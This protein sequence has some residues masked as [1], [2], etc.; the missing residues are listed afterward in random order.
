MAIDWDAID[1]EINQAAGE[2]DAQLES[3]ISSLTRMKDNE[4]NE[5]FPEKADKEKLIKLMQIVNEATTENK[6]TAHLVENIQDLAGTA[7]KLLTRFV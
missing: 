1:E 7:V 2:T 3:K 5:L 4:I 6:R